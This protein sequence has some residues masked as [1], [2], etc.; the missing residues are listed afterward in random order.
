MWARGVTASQGMRRWWTSSHHRSR[1]LD[2]CLE[3]ETPL[4]TLIVFITMLFREWVSKRR[5]EIRPWSDFAKTSHF[6]RPKTVPKLSQRV[7]KNLDHFQSNYVFVFLILFL[8]CLVTSP[9]LLIVMAA[10]GGACY[11]LSIKQVGVFLVY[12][13]VFEHTKVKIHQENTYFWGKAM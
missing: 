3:A 12:F 13:C 7:V 4:T 2:A 6:D 10:S 5:E 11:I 9:L 8:Y 1:S